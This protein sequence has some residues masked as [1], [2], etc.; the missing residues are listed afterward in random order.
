MDK[1]KKFRNWAIVVFLLFLLEVFFNFNNHFS[2]HSL[3]LYPYPAKVFISIVRSPLLFLSVYLF[4]KFRE[5][6]QSNGL[7]GSAVIRSAGVSMLGGYMILSSIQ[8]II[9]ICYFNPDASYAIK[10]LGVITV[11]ISII[12]GFNILK[13]KEW[14][15][16][17]F[18]YYCIIIVLVTPF[19]FTNSLLRA[20]LKG[21]PIPISILELT[22]FLLL[23]LSLPLFFITRPKVKAQ[24][25]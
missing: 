2:H 16:K 19:C 25:K 13:L 10:I 8:A 9:G 6:Q 23:I 11:P 12:L 1:S 4:L 15:R 17:G 21:T 18:V 20:K 14:A 5:I 22:I 3:A 7:T 24:F